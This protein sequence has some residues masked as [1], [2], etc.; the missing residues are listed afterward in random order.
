MYS[1]WACKNYYLFILLTGCGC[2]IMNITLTNVFIPVSLL[3]TKDINWF[4]DIISTQTP[5]P[6]GRIYNSSQRQRAPL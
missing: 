1:A 6:E 5:N 4:Y 2:V 3:L